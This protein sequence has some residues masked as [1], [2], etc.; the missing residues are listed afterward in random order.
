MTRTMRRA[1][2]TIAWAAIAL[3]YLFPYT[4][5]V[6]TGFRT[7]ID[8]ITMPPRLLFT[9]TFEGFALLFG[10]SAFG[11]YLVNSIVI[12]VSATLAIVA[13]ASPAAY[14][15]AQ[16]RM[17]ARAFLFALL[18]ARMIPGIAIVIPIYLVAA[19]LGQL[20][21]YHALIVIYT[22]FNLPFAIWLLRSFFR[23]LP[24][25]LREAAIIDGCSELGVFRRVMLP[26]VAGGIVATAVFVFIA[27]WNEFLFALVLTNSRAAT[28]PLAVL[29]YRN[30]Y[31]IQW[32][33][34]G[35]AAF[36]I[37]TPVVAFAVVMQRY[38]VRGLTMGSIK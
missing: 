12:A 14:A 25:E 17:R 8:T 21:T 1:L 27:A 38:L 15:L 9:P 20:D 24:P 32:S 2:L 29:G 37:S 16:L 36:L 22:A 5:M 34:I 33:A 30:E 10:A 18:V 28:A 7:P 31:G 3:V 35:A 6:M 23:E 26:L 19:K 11:S 13:L 4:W